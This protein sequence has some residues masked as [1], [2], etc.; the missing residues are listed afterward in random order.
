MTEN[1]W[2]QVKN[3]KKSEEVVLKTKNIDDLL[4]LWFIWKQLTYEN[5]FKPIR[6]LFRGND[7]LLFYRCEV[8]HKPFL[9]AFLGFHDWL[10]N[11]SHKVNDYPRE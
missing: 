8:M 9:F 11:E 5:L 3:L 4:A 6:Q 2:W 7:K 1:N 10:H